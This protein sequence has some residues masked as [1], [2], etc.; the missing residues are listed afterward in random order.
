MGGLYDA[1][2]LRAP[3]HQGRVYSKELRGR[4]VGVRRESVWLPRA[5]RVLELKMDLAGLGGGR[6]GPVMVAACVV[7]HGELC[8]LDEWENCQFG[9]GHR[10]AFLT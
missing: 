9:V 6:L 2:T 1:A 5:G 3:I 8:P 4:R 7:L 10:E